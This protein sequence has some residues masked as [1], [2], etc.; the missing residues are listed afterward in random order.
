MSG[1]EMLYGRRHA[2]VQR[3]IKSMGLAPRGW[4][5]SSTLGQIRSTAYCLMP[6]DM[7]GLPD[8]SAVERIVVVA[9]AAAACFALGTSS[10]ALLRST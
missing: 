3:V 6:W 7:M 4:A 10:V 9:H 1:L 5:E 2:D 8:M